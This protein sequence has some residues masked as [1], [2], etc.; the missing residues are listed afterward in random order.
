MQPKIGE[1]QN[2]IPKLEEMDQ[3]S[4]KTGSHNLDMKKKPVCGSILSF[5]EADFRNYIHNQVKTLC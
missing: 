1:R 4:R 3:P 5:F 2:N